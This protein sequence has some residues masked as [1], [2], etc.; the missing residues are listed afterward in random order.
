MARVECEVEF[1]QK[2]NDNGRMQDGVKVTCGNCGHSEFS[3]GTKRGSVV[4]CLMLLKENCPEGATNN[5]YV[6]DTDG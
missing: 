4:R 5:F 2:E 6:G 1:C 3:W